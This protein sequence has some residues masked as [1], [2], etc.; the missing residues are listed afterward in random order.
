MNDKF[1]DFFSEN[2]FDIHEPHSGHNER[3]L[4]KLQ[5]PKKKTISYK[6]MGAVA[7]VILLIGFYLGSF[8]QQKQYDLRD[9]SPKMA[10]AQNF[11]VSTINQELKE[12]EKFRNLETETLIEEALEEIEEL[13]DQYG[14]FKIELNQSG[15]QRMKVQAMINN[16]QQRLHVLQRLLDQLDK[17]ENPTKFNNIDDE[18]I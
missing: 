15:N 10:E 16:Y 14:S 1:Q 8:H 9:V 18:I 17:L 7:S 3:F 2:N 4:R 13:E 11:F 12:I 6:L 5:Q